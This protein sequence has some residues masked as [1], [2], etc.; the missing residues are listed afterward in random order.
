MQA[1]KRNEYRCMTLAYVIRSHVSM[2]QSNTLLNMPSLLSQQLRAASKH[3]LRRI[4][5]GYT[6][7]LSG[8]WQ[9]NPT[10]PTPQIKYATR[11]MA[12]NIQVKPHVGPTLMAGKKIVNLSNHLIGW[13]HGGPQT[14][15]KP[16]TKHDIQSRPTPS[17]IGVR[18]S[19]GIT[20][21]GNPL[22]PIPREYIQNET[23]GTNGIHWKLPAAPMPPKAQGPHVTWPSITLGARPNHA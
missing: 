7:A 18:V 12:T 5:S 1:A 3:C 21:Q 19:T 16:P 14:R 17:T 2:H 22:I 8:Q 11:L 4:Q 13:K 10:R 20:V 15:N 6:I 9:H 23:L